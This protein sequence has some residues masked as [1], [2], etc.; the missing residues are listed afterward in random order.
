[1][2]T[3]K[4]EDVRCRF[5]GQEFAV[6]DPRT[7][8]FA[9]T[10]PLVLARIIVNAAWPRARSWSSMAL[11]V[12]CAFLYVKVS[13]EIYIEELPSEDLLAGDGNFVGRLRKTLYGTRDAPQLWQ[14]EL[15]TTL[16]GLGFKG[17]RLDPGFFYHDGQNV[18]LVSHVDDRLI[19][20]D[21]RGSPVG[22]GVP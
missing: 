3:K 17:S 7:D 4:G 13:R 11:D 9:S 19:G 1:M 10:P 2:D 14:R 22:Q 15:E 21:A 20:G 18:A 5:V 6:G 16:N 12:S 8:L